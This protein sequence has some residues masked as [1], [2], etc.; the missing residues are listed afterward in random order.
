[1]FEQESFNV[2]SFQ[3]MPNFGRY[4]EY[5]QCSP[6][7]GYRRHSS[8]SHEDILNMKYQHVPV[9]PRY[10][11]SRPFVKSS[12]NIYDNVR[13]DFMSRR[14]SSSSLQEDVIRPF[15]MLKMN[16]FLRRS[17]PTMNQTRSSS[18]NVSD[19]SNSN[20][21][22]NPSHP[23]NPSIFIEE[24]DDTMRAEEVKSNNSS[25]N[26]SQSNEYQQPL[27]EET[28]APFAGCDE[29]PFIDDENTTLISAHHHHF[30]DDNINI[31]EVNC[32]A[33][34]DP[35]VELFK[36][37]PPPLPPVIPPYIKN[38]KTVSF[39]LMDVVDATEF[40]RI[41]PPQPLR[42]PPPSSLCTSTSTSHQQQQQQHQQMHHPAN[43]MCARA[44][45][46]NPCDHITNVM[47]N[48]CGKSAGT[49]ANC[50]FNATTDTNEGLL[51]QT[52][53]PIFKFCTFKRSNS[54]TK[55]NNGTESFKNIPSL[56]N[57]NFSAYFYEDDESNHDSQTI[58]N[59]KTL[60]S[61]ASTNYDTKAIT[62]DLSELHSNST[63]SSTT[64]YDSG[65]D[66]ASESGHCPQQPQSSNTAPPPPAHHT[67]AAEKKFA[68]IPIQRKL[69]SL[70][71]GD[72]N[73]C[74]MPGVGNVRALRNYFEQLK[75]LGDNRLT[76]SSP[77]LSKDS[78]RK[79]SAVERQNVLDQLKIWSEYGTSE[80]RDGGLM[81]KSASHTDP[82]RRS[83]LN[84][85]VTTTFDEQKQTSKIQ[86]TESDR[87]T[88]E[89][90]IDTC[91]TTATPNVN[92]H[93]K[94]PDSYIVRKQKITTNI[95]ATDNF[96]AQSCP[97]LQWISNGNGGSSSKSTAK[98]NT[99]GSKFNSKLKASIYNSPCHRSTY[100][101][102]R[103]IKQNKKINKLV[104]NS[105]SSSGMCGG[106]SNA[107][108]MAN[109]SD[110]GDEAR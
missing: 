32:V 53:E 77:N 10:R 102:L 51:N 96:Y 13:R 52:N 31:P 63:N 41:A 20:L 22:L 88:S 43:S 59:N 82:L 8:Y 45:K 49:K 5:L 99:N 84:L 79:L 25:T 98:V 57:D 47:L 17:S 64:Q 92:Q 40:S 21:N 72:T 89:P 11:D 29:I 19:K 12:S 44:E 4:N 101:T 80:I 37:P 36:P 68:Y 74:R 3:P 91:S 85:T 6:Q 61:A 83:V 35:S 81:R 109:D 16:E 58:T 73:Q 78:N 18:P 54:N 15:Q 55:P 28:V 14:R 67:Q 33:C 46:S 56:D 26:V 76:R 103:K 100:L 62:L 71:S 50:A 66:G 110:G 23:S 104:K 94:F 60:Q 9:D 24:Y 65:I 38:R 95:H 42:L 108:H 30:C 69:P 90:S 70:Q 48:K 7:L 93:K 107:N 2:P 1:M 86:L 87:S 34:N 106:P 27:S 105:E 39:D 75:M 97:N